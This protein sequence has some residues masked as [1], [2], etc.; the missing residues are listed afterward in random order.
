MEQIIEFPDIL[1]LIEHNNLPTEIYAPD[2][3]LLMKPYGTWG[4][5]PL[6]LNRK[7]WRV[8]ANYSLTSDDEIVQVNTTGQLIRVGKDVD[9]NEILGYVRRFNP[10][11]TVEEVISAILERVIEDTG[12]FKNDDEFMSYAFLLYLTLA[13]AIHYGLL[14]LVKD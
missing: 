8:F 13:Y 9:T 1:K 3:T 11:A 5:Q 14:I 2:G 10:G 12:Q 4:E 6:V 7:V